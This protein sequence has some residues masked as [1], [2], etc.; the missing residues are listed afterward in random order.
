MDFILEENFQTK[1][2]EL[3]GILDKMK[4]KK[5]LTINK[6]SSI[7]KIYSDCWKYI[8]S[9]KT[10]IY[11]IISLF[12][13]F[14][15]VGFFVPAPKEIM[16]LILEYIQQILEQTKDMSVLELISF[17]FLNNLQ[18][19]FLGLILGIFIGFFP[20]LFA[21]FNGY[22]LGIVASLTVAQE[23]ALSLINILPHGIFE[24]PAVFIA[25][26]LGL[27]LGTFVFQKNKLSF[28]KR[29]L[30]ESAKVFLFV[31]LPLLIIAAIIEGSL[32]FLIR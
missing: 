30:S 1:Q 6:K 27:N 9:C 24:L 2:K 23:G 26:G 19:S 32:I 11:W 28:F 25:L 13:L 31:V 4:S 7:L 15:I 8:K 14:S 29:N 3:R 22:V 10:K 12:F 16:T 18:A 20:I 17:I 5:N 21:I